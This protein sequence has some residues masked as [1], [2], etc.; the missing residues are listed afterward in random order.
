MRCQLLNSYWS[1]TGF[2]P[3]WTSRLSYMNYKKPYKT[4]LNTKRKLFTV[5]LNKERL[6]NKG[7]YVQER[8]LSKIHLILATLILH[9]KLT[10]PY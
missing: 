8:E 5:R 4:R 6:E 2:H 7:L 1:L 3:Q 9:E 10:H